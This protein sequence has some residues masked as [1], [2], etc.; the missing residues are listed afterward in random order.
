M[1]GHGSPATSSS[2][3]GRHRVMAS[4][5]ELGLHEMPVSTDA[6]GAV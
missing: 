4:R 6:S 5:A 1:R 2:Q 3:L